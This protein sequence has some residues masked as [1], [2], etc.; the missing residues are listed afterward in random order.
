MYQ[1]IP[2]WRQALTPDGL[3]FFKYK[4]K[5]IFFSVK[6]P[7]DA[8]KV[9]L[10]FANYYGPEDYELGSCSLKAGERIYTITSEGNGKICIPKNRIVVTDEKEC[11]IR[12]GES[13]EVR[14]YSTTGKM[15]ENATETNI[16]WSKK[17]NWTKEENVSSSIFRSIVYGTAK[18]PVPALEAIEVYTECKPQVI[19]AF[20]DSITQQA[21]WVNPL[22]E[23]LYEK[24]GDK[25]ILL[26]SGIG[27]NRILHDGTEGQ[28]ARFG[29][30]AE[31]RFDRDV[32][33]IA[34]ITTVIIA[35]GTND[36]AQ[37]KSKDCQDFVT[38]EEIIAGYKRLIGRA[39]KAGIRVVGATILPA[40]GCTY[41]GGPYKDS[42]RQ[43]VNK[44]IRTEAPYDCV[45]DYDKAICDEKD[46]LMIKKGC[47]L[48]D[49]I[50]PNKRGGEIL[51][52]SVDMKLLFK[53]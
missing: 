35:V 40:K 12:K 26:N 25:V 51:A 4:N 41:Y 23:R 28:A 22:R 39:K 21:T 27:G 47:S 32:L 37:P 7:L 2:V 34:G 46:P 10:R 13:L 8:K 49:R 24:Y 42:M 29:E 48:H 15:N 33:S 38:V 53:D 31:K 11:R 30:S 17:G 52:R 43:E 36:I 50:H 18:R 5:T 44:W 14:L 19:V 1:W 45:L 16:F 3:T 9:R 20:G 6:C